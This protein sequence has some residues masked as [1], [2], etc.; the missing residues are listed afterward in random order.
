MQTQGMGRML[1]FISNNGQIMVKIVNNKKSDLIRQYGNFKT[2]KTILKH[3]RTFL[4]VTMFKRQKA[5]LFVV[6]C[7]GSLQLLMS[8]ERNELWNDS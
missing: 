3:Y 8:Q 4:N 7:V 1:L 6:F 2:F 5:Y